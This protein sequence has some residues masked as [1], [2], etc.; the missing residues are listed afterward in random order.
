MLVIGRVKVGEIRFIEA[1]NQFVGIF[2]EIPDRAGKI[3]E[4]FC[5]V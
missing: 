1:Q 4:S 2:P 5:G 3:G